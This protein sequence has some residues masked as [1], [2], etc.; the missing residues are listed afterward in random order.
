MQ[1]FSFFTISILVIILD[2]WSK[3]YFSQILS[4]GDIALWRDV[5]LTL[6]YNFGVAF[7]LPIK[8]YLQITLSGGLLTGLL[9]YA[10]R[11]WRWQNWLTTVA[12][13]FIFGGAVGNLYER[14]QGK[15][16]TDFIQIFSWY[17][18]F[19]FADSFIF[20]GVV[21]LLIFEIKNNTL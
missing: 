6:Q 13:A 4:N 19:N 14:I 5:I 9:I 7:S 15:G 16:V 18:V 21:L 2:L 11:H 10:H 1:L 12:T 3:H 20:M 17:P 8:G